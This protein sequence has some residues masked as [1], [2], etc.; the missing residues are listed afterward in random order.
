MYVVV[1]LVRKRV[2]IEKDWM[3]WSRG[4]RAQGWQMQVL[5][6]SWTLLALGV[7]A[8]ARARRDK[9]RDGARDR[10]SRAD[11]EALG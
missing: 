3:G 1:P 5:E 6:P 10:W 7:G 4:W 11:V 2:R 8:S 9:A